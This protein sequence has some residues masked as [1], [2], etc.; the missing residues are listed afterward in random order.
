[1]GEGRWLGGGHMGNCGL[2]ALTAPVILTAGPM[3][4]DLA[5]PA[6]VK[7]LC[8]LKD[9]RLGMS[10]GRPCLE[11][12]LGGHQALSTLPL[13]LCS[14]KTSFCVRDTH[15]RI[16]KVRLRTGLLII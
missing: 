1:M 5:S 6:L 3:L 11:I 12:L 9:V 7:V 15:L 10:V 2:P 14:L 13:H 8:S 16:L 4:S